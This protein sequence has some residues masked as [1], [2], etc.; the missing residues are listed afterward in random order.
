MIKFTIVGGKLVLDP[1]I[2]L[3]KVLQAL[4]DVQ[5]GPKYLQVIYYTHSTDPENPFKDLDSRVAE[6]NIITFN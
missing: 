6:E 2:V 4:Y 1:N 5:D 3:F